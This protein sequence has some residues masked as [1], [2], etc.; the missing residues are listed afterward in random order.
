MKPN[1]TERDLRTYMAVMQAIAIE[2]AKTM[3]TTPEI[4]RQ[5]AELAAFARERHAEIKRAELAAMP[6]NIVSGAVRP[7]I[8]AMA[9]DAVVARLSALFAEHP[10][11]G[12]CY[13]EFEEATDDDLRS[14]L[15]DVLSVL[16]RDE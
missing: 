12:L 10:Q 9:R 5:A 15:E 16:E 4:K 14:A 13:R 1:A 2:E 7:S 8:L 3:P 6:S 11:L